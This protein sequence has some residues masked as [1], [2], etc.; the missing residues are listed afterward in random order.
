MLWF[1]LPGTLFQHKNRVTVHILCYLYFDLCLKQDS[2]EINGPILPNFRCGNEVMP[3]ECAR[4]ILLESLGLQNGNICSIAPHTSLDSQTQKW[5]GCHFHR[6]SE[7]PWI[8]WMLSQTQYKMV[9]TILCPSYPQEMDN[10]CKMASSCVCWAPVLSL[11]LQ[12]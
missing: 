12:S 1:C 5:P 9:T 4:C 2:L 6:H 11:G 7:A 8:L 10:N 3:K